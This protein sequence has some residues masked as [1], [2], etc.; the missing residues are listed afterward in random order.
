MEWHRHILLGFF[1]WKFSAILLALSATFEEH[2][3][4]VIVRANAL[5]LNGIKLMYFHE[6]FQTVNI[7]SVKVVAVACLD[8]FVLTNVEMG[9]FIYCIFLLSALNFQ[10]FEQYFKVRVVFLQLS[11][12]F[13]FFTSW[14][15]LGRNEPALSNTENPIYDTIRHTSCNECLK[16]KNNETALNSNHFTFLKF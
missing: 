1:H 3:L 6:S 14:W 8:H 16:R 11:F 9:R 10:L 4:A 13:F 5:V 7:I 12:L 15:L 2:L